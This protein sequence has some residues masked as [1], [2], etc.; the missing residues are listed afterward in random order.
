MASYLDFVSY[1]VAPTSFCMIRLDWRRLSYCVA[2][3]IWG[4]VPLDIG[5]IGCIVGGI[6]SIS[7]G[8]CRSISRWVGC[9]VGCNVSSGTSWLHYFF[10]T[11][12]FFSHQVERTLATTSLSRALRSA[13]GIGTCRG[14]LFLLS[15][16]LQHGHWLGGTGLLENLQG[17]LGQRGQLPSWSAVSC[18]LH[19]RRARSP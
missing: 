12:P 3:W 6:A 17:G 15:E 9:S 19:I 18:R 11:S 10:F 4:R 1:A 8:V 7:R 16:Q 13:S 2:S 5:S 14:S